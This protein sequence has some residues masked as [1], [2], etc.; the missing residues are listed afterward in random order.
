MGCAALYGSDWYLSRSVYGLKSYTYVT[1]ERPGLCNGFMDHF[2]IIKSM[3]VIGLKTR[4]CGLQGGP[5][6]VGFEVL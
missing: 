1:W 2:M 5:G 4:F 6:L 3:C